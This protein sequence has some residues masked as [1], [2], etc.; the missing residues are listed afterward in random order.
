[1]AKK[2][3]A[4][5][6][7][8]KSKATSDSWQIVLV[9]HS[10]SRAEFYQITDVLDTHPRHWA[11]STHDDDQR[12]QQL[13]DGQFFAP[14][15][16][17][18]ACVSI[19]RK[20]WAIYAG[21]AVDTKTIA[22]LGKSRKLQTIVAGFDAEKAKSHFRLYKEG[23]VFVDYQAT[24]PS[25]ELPDELALKKGP[26]PVKACLTKA[27][28]GAKAVEALLKHFDANGMQMAIAQ[29]DSNLQ[30]SRLDGKELAWK[31]VRKICLITFYPLM[32]K[33][34]PGSDLMDRALEE[35]NPKKV[36]KAIKAGASL[37]WL[38][39]TTSMSP[40]GMAILNKKGN[41]KD[42]ARQLVKAG[43]PVDGGP[44]ETPP[45]VDCC[46]SFGTLN[47]RGMDDRSRIE[48]IDFLLK[49][50]AD[51]DAKNCTEYEQGWTALHRAVKNYQT[52]LVM[53]LVLRGAK[54]DAKAADGQSPLELARSRAE[55]HRLDELNR[56]RTRKKAVRSRG[57]GVPKVEKIV[58][59]LSGVK[60]KRIKRSDIPAFVKAELE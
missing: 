27:K 21:P 11:S 13:V 3:T 6:A 10:K 2:K 37:R 20:K 33:E 35:G 4:K 36:V 28:T 1:M 57:S 19:A 25:N 17:W 60:S 42:C 55:R 46:L 51:I 49:L 52:L 47:V 23:K 15:I 48:T 40:F 22:R 9:K 5:K 45:L 53:Y 12:R 18:A 44:G 8:S 16:P 54:I 24:G 31:N 58:Q 56:G 7:A 43:A 50:G 14:V 39:E 59:F 26:K 41:W 32:S 34:N 29:V 30:L 38:P